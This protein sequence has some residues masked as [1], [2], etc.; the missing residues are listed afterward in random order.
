MAHVQLNNVTVE[1]PI[2]TQ[3]TQSLKTSIL[4]RLGGT[5]SKHNNTVIVRALN[6]LTMELKDG[7]RLGI[8]GPNGAG[9]TTLLRVIS[10][11][12][13]PQIGTADINGSISSFTDLTLGMDPEA[14]GWENITFRCVFMGLTFA[15]A[16]E[17]SSSIAEFS[18][19]GGFLDMPVRTY[20]AGMF[21]RLAFAISTS[22]QPDIIVMDELIGAGDAQFYQKAQKRLQEL[23]GNTKILVLAS[24]DDN[25][26]K[27]LCNKGLWLEHGKVKSIGPAKDVVKQYLESVGG[28]KKKATWGNDSSKKHEPE[29][30][31][32]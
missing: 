19:L 4:G 12:Y 6:N 23:I 30:S 27:D 3:H 32:A 5:L 13:E 24:H 10:R 17:L 1:Y 26:I 15:R 14:N 31:A 9:K 18:E 7:D 29:G 20:S 16:R 11:I 25:I 21:I 8:V 28:P 2:F 22:V